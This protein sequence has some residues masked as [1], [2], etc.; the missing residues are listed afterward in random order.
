MTKL[1]S[2]SYTLTIRLE[3]K[4]E[5]GIFLKIAKSIINAKGE[6]VGIDVV[7][8]SR[9]SVIKDFIIN[10]RDELHEKEILTVIEKIKGIKIIQTIDRTFQQHIG[11]KIEIRNKILIRDYNDLSRLYT[12]GVARVCEA[13]CND[14]RYLYKYTIKQNTVAIVTDGS[15]VLGLGDIGPEAALPV[16]EGKAVVFKEF[17]NIDAFPICLS[18]RDTY[19]VCDVVKSISTVFGGI[20][21]E[22]ISAPRCFEIE[23]LLKRELDIPVFHDDQHGTAIVVLAALKNALK[24]VKKDFDKIKVT[25]SGAGAA[26]TATCLLLKDAGINNIIVCDS[27]GIIYKGRKKNMNEI[28]RWLSLNTNKRMIKGG[29]SD[30]IKGSDVFIGLSAPH[31]LSVDDIKSMAKDPIVFALANPEP[32]I[33]PED[34]YPYARIVATGRSDYPNQINNILC[35]PGLFRGLLNVGATMIDKEIKL[36]AAEAIASVVKESEL[37][38]EYIIPSVFNKKVVSA[39]AQAVES[40]AYNKKIYR[41]GL[42]LWM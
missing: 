27:E 40:A 34:I 8:A 41:K 7:R 9:A 5:P 35:F 22:D 3:F 15:A 1:P 2:P 33:A 32:E 29:L 21:L 10:A 14:K 36:S 17:A 13:I 23:S 4:N 26:G 16:M 39:V 6:I 12:P 18:V 37:S 20:N 38:E 28:K 25:I 19:I 31:I 42:N 11:G 30:A 24:I